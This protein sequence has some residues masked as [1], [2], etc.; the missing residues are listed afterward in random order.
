L[1]GF[2]AALAAT[3]IGLQVLP[4]REASRR[5]DL[6]VAESRS[7]LGAARTLQ[8][9][10]QEV[11]QAAFFKFDHYA[12]DASN[13]L[14][15]QVVG[16]APMVDHY[17]AE[18]EERLERLLQEDPGRID[19]LALL[20]DV[21]LE[22]AT[23]AESFGRRWETEDLVRRLGV[24]GSDDRWRAP[25]S[26]SVATRPAGAILTMRRYF[27][28][29][30]RWAE[31]P[32][33]VLGESPTTEREIPAGSIVLDV[34]LP[35]R[36]S[37]RLPVLL[38]RGEA[39]HVTIDLPLSET[40]PEGFVY[41][42]AGQ[43]LYGSAGGE[44]TRAFY[45]SQPAHT[46]KTG[47]YLIARNETTYGEWIEFLET[48]PPEERA[49]RSPNDKRQSFKVILTRSRDGAYTLALGSE[50]HPHVAKNAEMIRYTNRRTHAVQDWL[51]MPVTGV[52][53][54]D[55]VAYTKWLSDTHRV[56]RARPCTDHEW[57]RAARGA[58][59]RAYPHGERLEPSDAN[60]DLTY[61]H[62]ATTWGPDEVGSHPASDSPFGVHDMAGNA[63]EWVRSSED[64][65]PA[66]ARSG[67][68]MQWDAIARSENRAKDVVTRREA[69][70]GIRVCA[71]VTAAP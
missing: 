49:A 56:P 38:S 53:Y 18:A 21:L 54:E 65:A 14:W 8:H 32:A 55:L 57:E 66:V 1:L 67:G 59:G 27:M 4:A 12:S 19:A 50:L 68:F 63:W 20:G 3:V 9:Q 62:D 33:V 61:G 16:I 23:L 11:R 25:A 64:E 17:Y 69:F 15:K 2:P 35:G 71:T 34:S 47:A 5:Q 7:K 52:S 37:V 10:L 26:I 43:F 24:Y 13:G 6:V 42:P 70:Y 48:L 45:L 46:V 58:D 30:G 44:E 40:I 36:A 41:I 51:R 22:R 60:F 28:R 29:D 31:S 39:A